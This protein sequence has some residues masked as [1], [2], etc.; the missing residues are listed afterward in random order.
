MDWLLSM[1]T[2][3]GGSDKLQGGARDSCKPS[4]I[5]PEAQEVQVYADVRLGSMRRRGEGQD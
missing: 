1:L 2:G 5:T 4:D 3:I